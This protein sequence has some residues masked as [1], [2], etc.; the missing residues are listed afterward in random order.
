[1][2]NLWQFDEVV[3]VCPR[4]PSLAD[5]PELSM[6][7]R[8]A[9]GR[10]IRKSPGY[11]WRSSFAQGFG[12]AASLLVDP[13]GHRAKGLEV[14]KPAVIRATASQET[15]V[16]RLRLFG[17]SAIHLNESAESLAVALEQGISLSPDTR[18]RTPIPV[19]RILLG[20]QAMVELPQFRARSATLILRTPL[21]VRTGQRLQPEPTAIF[22]S[23]LNRVSS[24]CYWQGYRLEA[25]WAQ[26]HHAIANL[27]FDTR[28]LYAH[29]WQRHSIRRG[30]EPI[31]VHGHLGVLRV[32]GDLSTLAPFLLLGETCNTGSH[33]SLGLG[34]YELALY[35]G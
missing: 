18:V 15:L 30:D 14:P 28:E 3:V 24:M 1:L 10:A 34:W 21:V 4:P 7:V 8:G 13:A 29:R 11:A 31:P 17:F 20:R 2:A 35:P 26:L 23:L 12:R 9:W 6:R 33:A 5:F 16:V 19:T 25:D 32:A 22:T 27:D